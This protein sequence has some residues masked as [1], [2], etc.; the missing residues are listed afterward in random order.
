MYLLLVGSVPSR[1]SM[2][3][4]TPSLAGPPPV[5]R[6]QSPSLTQPTSTPERT[7]ESHRSPAQTGSKPIDVQSEA[8]SVSAT[9]ASS[10]PEQVDANASRLSGLNLELANKLNSLRP[11]SQHQVLTLTEEVSDLN[12]AVSNDQYR[13]ASQSGISSKGKVGSTFGRSTPLKPG[14]TVDVVGHGSADGKT[15]G[16][17]TPQQL[18]K[19]LKDGGATQLAV[20]DLKSCHSDAFKV[21]LEQCLKDVGIKV[22][23]IKTYKGNVAI[24]RATGE[25]MQGDGV[26]EMDGHDGILPRQHYL[27]PDATA[28]LEPTYSQIE[29]L[30]AVVVSGDEDER[31]EAISHLQ[32]I[33]ANL[34]DRFTPDQSNLIVDKILRQLDID[35]PDIRFSRIAEDKLTQLK[36]EPET[37]LT[38]GR[39]SPDES[40]SVGDKLRA[41]STTLA[42][43]D[44]ETKKRNHLGQDKT[45]KIE[46]VRFSGSVSIAA[47]SDEPPVY[48][49][50]SKLPA[51]M[52]PMNNRQRD[53]LTNFQ[54]DS[55]TGNGLTDRH[56]DAEV[57]V[58]QELSVYLEETG[59]SRGTLKIHTDRKTCMSCI[60]AYVDFKTKHPSIS[61]QIS[62]KG[63]I[64]AG[65]RDAARNPDPVPAPSISGGSSWASLVA[66]KPPPPPPEN[67]EWPELS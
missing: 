57:K 24:S 26:E 3:P 42:Y 5:N 17:K 12:D 48:L 49:D 58:L 9:I 62:F 29:E 10:N 41:S 7:A 54:V 19:L 28:D 55:R 15:V 6:L 59:I 67:L 46:L 23:E 11:A 1:T 52:S 30:Y 14:G 18:A 45:G 27:K 61:L 60:G 34:F 35:S 39:L 31:V 44:L 36:S 33:G 65:E 22:G 13:S 32:S 51:M 64:D 50:E 40:A 25:V 16:G 37:F 38:K 53:R 47:S 63:D 43:A 20:L 56:N 4:G 8:S 2:P 66:K 21:E